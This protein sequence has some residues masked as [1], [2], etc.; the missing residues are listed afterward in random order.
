MD[1]SNPISIM[2]R[3]SSMEVDL[4]QA[5]NKSW[6][7]SAGSSTG[8]RLADR[9]PAEYVTMVQNTYLWEPLRY[10]S[11]YDLGELP[12]GQL[13][14]VGF[15]QTHLDTFPTHSLQATIEALADF[16]RT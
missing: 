16:L 8:D 15:V 1:L 2:A 9:R 11:L 14:C 6:G 5:R 10:H 13:S 3:V 7:S 4:E 12:E